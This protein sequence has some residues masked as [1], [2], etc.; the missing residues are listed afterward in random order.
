M[1]WW[2]A[3]VRLQKEIEELREAV[4]VLE[5]KLRDAEDALLRLRKARAALEQDVQTKDRSLDIDSK[6]C[7]GMR[8][9]MATEPKSCPMITEPLLL[10]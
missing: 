8:K 1:T 7:L 10:C 3:S 2:C 9:R 5:E 6:V 4:R